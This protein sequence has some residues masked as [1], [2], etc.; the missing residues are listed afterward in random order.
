MQRRKFLS[1]VSLAGLTLGLPINNFADKVLKTKSFKNMDQLEKVKM[2]LLG[3]MRRTWEQGVAM[4]AML[5]LGEEELVILMAKDAVLYQ[6]PDGRMCMNN[7]EDGALSDACSPGEAVLWAAKKTG[8]KNLMDGFNKLADYAMNKA[9]RNKEGIIFHFANNQQV[10]SDINYMLPPFLAIA[11]KYEEAIKQ[12]EGACS[13][14]MNKEKNL[15]MHQWDCEKNIP[16]RKDL[17][18]VGKGWTAAG[19]ARIIKQLPDSMKA[20]KQR[21]INHV[22]GI[23]DA[24]LVYQREDG[25]FHDVVDNPNSFIETNLGQMLAYT[26]YRGVK[27]GWLSRKYLEKADKMRKAAHGKVDELGLVQG[28]CGAPN[29]DRSSVAAEGQSFFIMMEVAHKDLV[30]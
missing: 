9:P 16:L 27:A 30:K 23:I 29:F 7:S 18:G 19:G 8:N 1:S 13:L 28:V 24:A 4:Q 2:A 6:S 20:E 25:L 14:L 17:W 21:M 12:F 5:E 15:L 10:W 11:G 3:M 26:I 22:K